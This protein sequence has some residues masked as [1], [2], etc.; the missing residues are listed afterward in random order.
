M[1]KK[2]SYNLTPEYQKQLNELAQELPEIQRVNSNTGELCFISKLVMVPW[3]KLSDAEKDF[4]SAPVYKKMLHKQIQKVPVL[5]NHADE[6]Y[7]AF[8]THGELGVQKY[9]D[10]INEITKASNRAAQRVTRKKVYHDESIDQIE[11][12]MQVVNERV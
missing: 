6:L 1:K 12:M 8:R 2:Y 7:K 5:F 11:K 3:S 9:I 4:F 10:K